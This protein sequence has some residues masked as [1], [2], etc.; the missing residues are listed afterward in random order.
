MKKISK[1]LIDSIS[2]KFDHWT[3]IIFMPAVKEVYKIQRGNS[4]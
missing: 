4:D 1:A 3:R 2:Q